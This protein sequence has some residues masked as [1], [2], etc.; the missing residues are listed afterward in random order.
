LKF[1]V[2]LR[3][4]MVI[5]LCFLAFPVL[6]AANIVYV[7]PVQGVISD[8]LAQQ[9]AAGIKEAEQLQARAIILEIDTPGGAIGAAMEISKN[10]SETQIPTVSF[11]NGDALSAGALIAFSTV[12]IAM[13]PG[14]TIGAAEPRLGTE[15]ADEKIVSAWTKKLAGVAQA[16]GRNPEIAAAMSDADIEIPGLVAKGKLLTLTHRQAV[17]T[18]MADVVKNNRREVLEHFGFSGAQVMVR[19]GSTAEQ[20]ARWV[21]HPFVSPVLL[22]VGVAGLL[23]EVFTVGFGVAGTIGLLSLALFFGGHYLAGAS[24][25]EAILMFLAGIIL[26]ALEILVI[27]GFG[28]AGVGGII[29]LVISIVLASVSVSQAIT[30]ILVALVGSIVLLLVSVRFLPTRKWWQ[31]LIL[32]TKQERSTGYLASDGKGETYLGQEGVA[33]TPLRPSGTAEIAG[34]PVDVVADQGYLA[35]G[36]KVKVVKVEG[37]RI[38]VRKSGADQ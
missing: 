7:I 23:L 3:G 1:S 32:S 9:V 17:E 11:I 29:L 18:G 27:P 15:K 14:A 21:T 24:G 26:L 31:R 8:G 28:V 4:L 36:T 2:W 37:R 20:L 13:V 30:S 38:V 19:R 33:L 5:F 22:T 25:L 16:H 34:E 35:R 12:H 10:L 6:A